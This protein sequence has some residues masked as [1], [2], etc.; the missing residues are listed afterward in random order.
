MFFEN[1]LKN[2]FRYILDKKSEFQKLSDNDKNEFINNLLI[3]FDLEFMKN[4]NISLPVGIPS[5]EKDI[6]LKDYLME[7]GEKELDQIIQSTM[8]KIIPQALKSLSKN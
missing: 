5:E 1:D 6:F 7:M 2:S 4:L 3:D 8:D